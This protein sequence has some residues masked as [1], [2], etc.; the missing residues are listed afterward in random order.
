[1]VLYVDLLKNRISE[2]GNRLTEKSA[3]ISYLTT[4]LVTKSLNTLINQNSRRIDH[5]REPQISN[6]DKVNE[7][8]NM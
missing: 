4:Q 7:Y 8:A 1:M 2:M 6:S 3:I 5:R